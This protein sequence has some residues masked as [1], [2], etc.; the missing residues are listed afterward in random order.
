MPKLKTHKSI[1]K[2]YKLT[3]NNKLLR[4]HAGQ[5]HFNARNTG[6]QTREKRGYEK[7][8]KTNQDTIKQYLPYHKK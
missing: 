5:D 3:K 7:V 1:T 6:D 8:D 4:K 2:R